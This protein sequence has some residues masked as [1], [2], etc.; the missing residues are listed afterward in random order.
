VTPCNNDRIVSNRRRATL[1]DRVFIV[2][3]NA[4]LTDG[5]DCLKKAVNERCLLT[6]DGGQGPRRRPGID[7][8]N[9]HFG[10]KSFRTNFILKFRTNF[11]QKTTDIKLLSI[12]DKNVGLS[13]ILKPCMKVRS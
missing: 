4:P 6:A 10:R 11:R 2:G 13:G 5:N 12:I 1:R 9:L 7:S 3:I 8:M